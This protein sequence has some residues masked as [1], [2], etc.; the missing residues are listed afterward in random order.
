MIRTEAESV[1]GRGGAGVSLAP[2]DLRAI[3][4]EAL[5]PVP[6]GARVLA[7]VPDR[8]RDD[9]THLLVPIASQILERKNIARLDALVAQGTHPPMTEAQK[10]EKVGYGNGH[11]PGLERIFDHQWDRAADLV[12]LGELTA[13]RV[14]ALTGGLIAESVPVRLN[15]LLAPGLYDY[16]LVFGATM[17]HEVA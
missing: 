16:V 2:D 9:N 4:T 10:C 8:T 13:D 6:A 14:K 12:T 15:S 5:A 7:I 17:P 11:M 1:V 3:V